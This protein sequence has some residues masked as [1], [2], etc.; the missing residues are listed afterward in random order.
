M[1]VPARFRRVRFGVFEIDLHEGELL[2]NGLKVRLQEQPFQVLAI[3]LSHPGKVVT[4]EELS[5]TLWP[6][7]TFVDF[8]AGLNTVIKRL[9][10]TL[11]DPADRPRYI[12][13]VPPKGVPLHRLGGG[14]SE[15]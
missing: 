15:S 1:E 12:E 3:L 14:Q 4:R 7:D 2:K 5:R 10:D 9:R 6:A 11:D 13:T 8:D